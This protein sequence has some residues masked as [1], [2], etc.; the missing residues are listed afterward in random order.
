YRAGDIVAWSLEG[1]KG[2]RPHI[3]V[4]TDRIGRS[5]RPLI[6]HNIGAGPKLK[7]ALF[8]WPMTGRYRP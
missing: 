4:V 7:G 8:D 3:G 5:G 2:F 1:G 6:A